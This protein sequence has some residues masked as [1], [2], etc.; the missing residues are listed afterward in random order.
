M[1]AQQL[2]AAEFKHS[3]SERCTVGSPPRL[4]T[5]TQS[6]V[7]ERFRCFLSG[8][9]WRRGR[10][11]EPRRSVKTR[12]RA[13]LTNTHTRH[14]LTPPF[15]SFSRP[16]SPPGSRRHSSR[17]RPRHLR[18][19]PSPCARGSFFFSPRR[20]FSLSTP[21][22]PSCLVVFRDLRERSAR[23]Q[24]LEACDSL[25]FFPSSLLPFSPPFFSSSLLLFLPSHSGLLCSSLPLFL[26]S[27]LPLSG[28]QLSDVHGRARVAEPLLGETRRPFEALLEKVGSGR[29]GAAEK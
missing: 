29:E 27:S 24:I 12:V 21:R 10:E 14:T 4:Q 20:E 13:S 19:Q 25:S 11:E 7:V 8:R 22:L 5:F 6:G 23:R 17:D 16:L 1:F 15:S 3:C 2:R 26:S 9:G 18:E 28:D